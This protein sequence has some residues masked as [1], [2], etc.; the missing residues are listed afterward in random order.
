M[1]PENAKTVLDFLLPSLEQEIETTKKV[2]AAAPAAKC[3][4]KPDPK[5]M[6]GLELAWHIASADPWLIG[7]AI[8]G[9]FGDMEPG[10]PAEIKT[11]ADALAYYESKMA[12]LLPRLRQLSP[13]NCARV[14]E[15]FSW[16]L[17]AVQYIH[18]ALMH[19]AHHRGQM[20]T[21]LRP[22]G[23]KVPSIYGGSADEAASM[24]ADSAS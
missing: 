8:D 10:I 2:L 6:S 21:Y 12:E 7:G 13:E 11:P 9:K 23:G 20:S 4:Y 15:F 18:L 14:V 16:K 5:N 24:S 19:G 17:P 22:M 1:S 3:D